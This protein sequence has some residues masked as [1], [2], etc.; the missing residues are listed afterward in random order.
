[1]PDPAHGHA[2]ALVED[3]KPAA[4]LTVATAEYVVLTWRLL[5]RPKITLLVPLSVFDFVLHM[6]Q[7]V[8]LSLQFR[9]MHLPYRKR[10][11][12]FSRAQRF[13]SYLAVLIY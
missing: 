3:R 6:R 1:M 8:Q 2:A 7:I 13:M 4:T 12:H 5:H 9:T 10:Q 11:M